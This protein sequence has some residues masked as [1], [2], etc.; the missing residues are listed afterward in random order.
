MKKLIKIVFILAFVGIVAAVVASAVS[1]KKLSS[2]SDDEIRAFLDA[3]LSGKVGED[4][5]G[6]IQSAVIAGVRR[7]GAATAT[8]D[9]AVEEVEAAAADLEDVAETAGTDVGEESVEPAE[10]GSEDA[11][12]ASEEAT[13]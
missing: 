8:V 12:S 6:S 5:L 7:G 2:M 3:K 10:S 4:Q 11:A 1:K 13:A 9:D